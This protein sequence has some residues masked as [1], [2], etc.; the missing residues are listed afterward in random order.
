MSTRIQAAASSNAKG[1]PPSRRHSSV[2]AGALSP[3]SSN[4]PGPSRIRS[5]SSRIAGARAS[6]ASSPWAGGTSRASTRNSRSPRSRSATRLVTRTCSSRRPPQQVGHDGCRVQHLLEVVEHQQ[7]VPLPTASG[8]A[9]PPAARCPAPRHRGRTRWPPAPGRGVGGRREVD[10]ARRRPATGRVV[11][12]IAASASRVFPMPPAPVSTS[13]RRWSRTST[14]RTRSSSRP[15]R[16]VTSAGRNPGVGAPAVARRTARASKVARSVRISSWSSAASVNRLYDNPPSA[17]IRSNMRPSG[18]IAGGRSRFDVEQPRQVRRPVQLVFEAGD[19][20]AGSDPAVAVGV[21]ADE[22]IGLRQIG[23]VHGLRRV[24]P[25][26]GLE[27]HRSEPQL[28]DRRPGRAALG[29]QFREGRGHEHPN[30]VVRCPDPGV[31]FH[32]PQRYRRV[33]H[34]QPSSG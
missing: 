13:Q 32:Q 31:V 15:T 10:E 24:R 4:P 25:G 27:H 19:G 18:R 33:P 23:P 14:I 9:R 21:D 1:R 8:A 16:V 29:R 28:L 6:S 22:D 20:H 17:L 26:P 30:S 3:V 12:S 5:T 34:V 7:H 11:R 2:S